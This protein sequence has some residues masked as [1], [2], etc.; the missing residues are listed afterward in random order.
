MQW[1]L[2]VGPG[3]RLAELLAYLVPDGSGGDCGAIVE[4]RELGELLAK[5]PAWNGPAR[6]LIDADAL[7][8]ADIGL[9]RAVM[10]HGTE[11][12]LVLLGEDGTRRAARTLARDPRVTWMAWPPDLHDLQR[13]G[14]APGKRAAAA[15]TN[16]PCV[17]TKATPRDAERADDEEEIAMDAVG[18]ELAQIE[19]I[20]GT[21]LAR[22]TRE[23]ADERADERAEECLAAP[24]PRAAAIPVERAPAPRTA[25]PSAERVPAPRAEAHEHD[26]E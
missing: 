5:E 6:L 3:A 26:L 21:P 15:T 22:R 12:E 9:V 8:V 24:S 25:P 17:S 4:L 1:S 10:K 18:D 16:E 7:D 14:R 11:L 13:L 19:A 2:I 20:L 23:R